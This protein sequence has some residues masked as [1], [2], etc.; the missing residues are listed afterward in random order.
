MKKVLCAAICGLSLLGLAQDVLAADLDYLRGSEVFEPQPATYERWSGFYFGGLAGYNNAQ[1]DFRRSTSPLVA[2]ML[3]EST[4]EVIGQISTWPMLG[5]ADRRDISWGG[6]IG[7]NSQWENAVLG[8]ELNYNRTSLFA[9]DTDSLRRIVP[10]GNLLYDTQVDADASM[11]LTDYGTLR[12][13]AGWAMGRFMPYITGGMALGRVETFRQASVSG[14]IT[15]TATGAT[16]PF[17][18]TQFENRTVYA[19]GYAAGAGV[20]V[21]LLPNV[22][23]RGEFEW[24][25]FRNLPDM[26]MDVVTGRVG[27]GMKF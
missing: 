8:I 5:T 7:Y 23:V 16:T 15:D 2:D 19:V 20:D 3:R 24:L 9:D 4:L 21:A 18:Q 26:K 12:A 13:R 22:F 11:R 6:F 14:T 17:G 25:Q 27:A 1:M 10:V